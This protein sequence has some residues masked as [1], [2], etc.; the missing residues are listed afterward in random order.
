MHGLTNTNTRAAHAAA[1]GVA[2]ALCCLALMLVGAFGTQRAWADGLSILAS[3]PEA[4]ESAAP[5]SGKYWVQFSN[6][7]VSV[8]SNKKH[9]T[10]QTA[11]GKAVSSSKYKVVLPDYELEFGYRQYVYLEIK[12]LEPNTAYRIHIAKGVTAKNLV[13]TL[14]DDVD[15]PFTTAASGT[16]AATLAEP[17]AV[18][19][20][21]GNGGGTGAGAGGAAGASA[22]ASASADEA[23][24]AVQGGSAQQQDQGLPGWALPVGIVVALA[25]VGIVVALALRARRRR[26]DGGERE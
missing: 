11:D 20:G 21:S 4:N 8:A 16:Q 13:N 15:I 18:A 9:V 2:L 22:S 26:G 17:T 24:P 23:A 10:L 6:N 12:G 5:T 7:V 19:G 14:S 25:A 1:F 3:A